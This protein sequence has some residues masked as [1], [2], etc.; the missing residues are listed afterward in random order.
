MASEFL[1]LWPK[2]IVEADPTADSNKNQTS[3]CTIVQKTR[4]TAIEGRFAHAKSLK[5]VA[6]L[7]CTLKTVFPVWECFNKTLKPF[8][9]GTGLK[10]TKRRKNELQ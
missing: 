9:C 10:V 8:Y 5:D 4:Q 6:K 7:V 1:D 2:E 3:S